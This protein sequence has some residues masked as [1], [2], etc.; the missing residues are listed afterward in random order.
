MQYRNNRKGEPVSLL[1][2][3]CMR[4]TRKGGSIDIDKAEREV[5][6]AIRAGVNYLDTAYLY[7][8]NEAAV[9]EILARNNCRER[10]NIATKL[11][12]YLIKTSSAIDRYF[13]EELKRLRTGY[14]DY[15][16]MHMLTDVAAWEK[17]KRLGIE[18][19]I[20][21]KKESGEIR[22]IGFSFHGNTEKFLE[23]LE[24]YDWDFCQIQYNYMD[25]N[26]QAGRKGL[27][28]A[29]AKGIPVIIMEP[30]RGGKLVDL[31][32]ESAKQ[33]IA[34]NSKKRSAAEWALRWLWEQPEVT[35]VL[36]GMNSMEMVEENIRIA[37]EVTP[38]EFT[39]EDRAMIEG[40]KQ[41]INRTIKVNCTG[42]QY[43]MPCPKGVDI[44]GTFRCYNE[45]YTEGRK[46]SARFEYAQNTALQKEM[47]DAYQCIECG[48]C[49]QHCPQ[50]LPIR[51][52]LKEA[53]KE[54]Q[55]FPYRVALKL[56]RLFKFW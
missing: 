3:G 30:L 38:H 18:E 20:A 14:I 52:H 10:V 49:E 37:S 12:Q 8:G 51:Q 32:P 25:E 24:A 42:C 27:Q 23:I 7:P 46:R 22:N 1:G 16:L 31:L 53:R 36:S 2:Y 56:L 15:Y 47:K 9:G 29:A 17:L 50:H 13:N 19:W 34:G 33:L 6:T 55:P 41:E 28:A 4:F 40:I 35:C 43:C 26:T 48:K 21:K 44:P 11:P 54:L 5:M 45:M 39:D